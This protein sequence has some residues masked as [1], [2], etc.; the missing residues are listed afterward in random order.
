MASHNN[1]ANNV[2]EGIVV[3]LTDAQAQLLKE[4]RAK[5]LREGVAGLERLPVVC[6]RC[7]KRVN[8][9]VTEDWVCQSCGYAQ[10]GIRIG[11]GGRVSLGGLVSLSLMALNYFKVSG[12]EK[13]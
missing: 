10:K 5:V 11:E 1:R 7:L 6:P 9:K 3:K 12:G 8:A 13:P 4:V 2:R